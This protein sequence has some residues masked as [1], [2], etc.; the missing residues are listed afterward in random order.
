MLIGN[1]RLTDFFALLA[2]HGSGE[3]FVFGE[4]SCRPPTVTHIVADFFWTI[5]DAGNILEENGAAV[6]YSYHQ[7]AQ[8]PGIAERLS[9]LDA[10]HLIL[11][12]EITGR[13]THVGRLDSALNLQR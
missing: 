1:F 5:L 13:L 11:A 10:D 9:R 7:I 12:A 2:Q 8:L 3:E 6:E 4:S